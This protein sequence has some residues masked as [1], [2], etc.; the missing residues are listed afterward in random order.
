MKD[1]SKCIGVVPLIMILIH[2]CG[3]WCPTH[4]QMFLLEQPPDLVSC[5]LYPAL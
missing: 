4:E 3:P 1:V 5:S 2:Q